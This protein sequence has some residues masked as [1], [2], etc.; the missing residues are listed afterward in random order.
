VSAKVIDIAAERLKRS[1]RLGWLGMPGH[2]IRVRDLGDGKIGIVN[3]H[4]QALGGLLQL[5]S[6]AQVHWDTP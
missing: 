2:G 6:H 3:G 5:A 1:E 4:H